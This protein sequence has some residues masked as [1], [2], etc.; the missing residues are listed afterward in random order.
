MTTHERGLK[1]STLPLTGFRDFLLKIIFYFSLVD[2]VRVCRVENIAQKYVCKRWI[3]NR[4]VNWSRDIVRS[5]RLTN[6]LC[7]LRGRLGL[8]GCRWNDVTIFWR[9]RVFSTHFI[10]YICIATFQEDDSG[11]CRTM[12]KEKCCDLHTHITYLIYII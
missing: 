12:A 4:L 10:T 5:W 1:V 9:T 2:F 7:D 3:S 11:I 6:G 8:I